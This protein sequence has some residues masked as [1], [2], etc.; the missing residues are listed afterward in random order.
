MYSKKNQGQQ[1]IDENRRKGYT[2]L[3]TEKMYTENGGRMKDF[4]DIHTHTIAS[5]HAYNTLEEMIQAG[6]SKNLKI[7]G[8]TEHAPAM[9]GTCHEFYFSNFRLV[10]RERNGMRLMLGVEANIMD[11]QGTLDLRERHL[12]NMDVV[13]ASLHVA[14]R[15]PG[16]LEENTEAVI[17]AIKNPYVNII[18]HPDDSRFPLDYEQVVQA[19]KENHVLLE[20]N[21]SSLSPD[22]YRPGAKENYKRMLELC[23]Q[24]S[25]PVIM[26]SDAHYRDFVGEHGNAIALFEELAFPEEL[27]VNTDVEKFLSFVHR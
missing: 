11:A 23:K 13:I 12:K 20:V 24:Y 1:E 27:V 2:I 18:G 15:K 8:I 3:I 22:S 14:C 19:A 9:P 16:T 26:G 10:P 4:I 25:V 21:N 7:M 5:G 17:N 6:L